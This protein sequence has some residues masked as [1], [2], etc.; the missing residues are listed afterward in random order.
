MVQLGQR[1]GGKSERLILEVDPKGS[2]DLRHK[3]N[4]AQR[5]N[6]CEPNAFTFMLKISIH[7]RV[8]IIESD[9]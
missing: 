3:L 9:P 7:D 2:G 5:K 8:I 6:A 4:D 1:S